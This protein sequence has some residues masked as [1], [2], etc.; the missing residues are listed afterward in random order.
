[1]AT[2]D[3]SGTKWQEVVTVQIRTRDAV[4]KLHT[5]GSCLP[6]QSISEGGG[7]ATMCQI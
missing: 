7:K 2:L 5:A 6:N 3:L 1:M 4:G